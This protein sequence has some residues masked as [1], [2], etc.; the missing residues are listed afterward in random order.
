[1]R[2][3][4]KLVT[5]SILYAVS[6]VIHAQ[7]APVG[8]RVQEDQAAPPQVQAAPL[9]LDRTFKKTAESSEAA[10]IFITADRLQARKDQELEASGAVELRSSD[11]TISAD[12]VLFQQNTKELT[13][14]GAVHIEQG[15]AA[16]SGSSLQMNVDTSVGNMVRPAFEFSD[17]NAR[18]SA[19]IMH[20]QGRKNFTFEDAS[21]TTCPIGNDDWQVRMS[22][23]E[24]DRNIQIG[25][26]HHAR[27]VF[28]DVPIFY[29]PWM[30]FPLANQRKSGFL[31][32]VFGG[33][34]KGGSEF[35]LPFYWNIASNMDATLA[36]RVMDKR[37]TLYN[38]EFRYMGNSFGSEM[39]YDVLPTDQI[40]KQERSHTALRHTQNLGGGVGGAINYNAVSDDAYYRDLAGSLNDAAQKN[41]L[42]EGVLTYG[43]PWWSGSVRVQ[44][45]Q[46]LQDPDA[47]V[48][49]PYKRLPQI[50]LAAQQVV[51]GSSMAVSAEYVDFSHPTSVNG[52]RV[53]LY[54]SVSYPLLRDPAYYITPK[55]AVH[56]TQ[57]TLG[58]NNPGTQ[59]HFERTVP[60]FSLD[61]GITLEREFSTSA[62]EYVQTLEPRAFYVYVPYVNQDMLPNFD[63]AQAPFTFTQMFMENRFFGN[64]R[65]GDANQVTLALTSRLLEAD[66]GSERLRVS[67]GERFSMETPRVNLVTPT[68][69]TNKSDILLSVGGKIN[70]TLALDSLVQYNPNE[71]RS[72]MY[73]GTARYTPEAGKVFNLGYRYS[74]DPVRQ[75]DALRQIDLSTQWLLHGRWHAVA[76]YNYSLLDQRA[77]EVLA[78]L[79]YNQDCWV[80]RMVGQQFAT[81]TNETSTGLFLQL[82]LNELIRVGPDPLEALRLSV[83]GYTKL[84]EIPREKPA[85]GLR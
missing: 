78:G 30:D 11:Q 63:T 15:G 31:G 16:V 3:R 50:N 58:V 17:S 84:N 52:N 34:N 22:E 80:V 57:Y 73:Y 36:P 9:K 46:T 8:N 27:I 48:A 55:L 56:N 5:L 76:R 26:A 72:E 54:P 64:D 67:L 77:V 62:T 83:P 43:A 45:Y 7:E 70:K 71:S 81:A 6:P 66:S 74:R 10:P 41:L 18:G 65:V 37:G 79:E 24:L 68:D 19:E 12:H 32:P 38:N 69:T 82:E 75:V 61:S 59:E 85:Q 44:R 1:M 23:L 40:S 60:I 13:A 35:T 33:T 53:V 42:Q 25:Q 4:I 49:I 51:A 21:Y 29:T 28:K 47:P 20:M 39:N 2:F 14:D